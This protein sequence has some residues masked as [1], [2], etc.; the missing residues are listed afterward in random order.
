MENTQ[1][2]ANGY[3]KCVVYKQ[4]NVL[5]FLHVA[6]Y[7]IL[8]LLWPNTEHVSEILPHIRH[9]KLTKFTKAHKHV[10][11]ITFCLRQWKL[12]TLTS[13]WSCQYC[14]V[15]MDWLCSQFIMKHE[16]HPVY[17]VHSNKPTQKA[18]QKRSPKL[19]KKHLWFT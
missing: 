14:F 19:H 6:F 12:T 16:K 17:I 18:C 1:L 4:C 11:Y 7:Q 13:S 5:C 2:F 9:D 15:F 3:R 8:C 10:I